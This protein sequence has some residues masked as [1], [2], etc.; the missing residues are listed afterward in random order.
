MNVV[1]RLREHSGRSTTYPARTR[2][3]W[4]VV[5]NEVI[6]R[7]FNEEAL[8][9]LKLAGMEE[10]VGVFNECLEDYDYF[11]NKTPEKVS[12]FRESY[13]F[14]SEFCHPNCY[15][16]VTGCDINS[17]GIVRY[18]KSAHMT[19]KDLIFVNYLLM[20]CHAFFNFYDKVFELLNTNEEVQIFVK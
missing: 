7:V 6:F 3:P 17:V 12:M 8:R 5:V 15:G 14:L 9:T 1:T 10:L 18:S 4:R 11:K 2:H 19:E 20:S 16:F 13:D